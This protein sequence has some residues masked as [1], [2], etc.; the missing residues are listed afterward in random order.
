MFSGKRS[1]EGTC[2]PSRAKPPGCRAAWPS[3]GPRAGGRREAGICASEGTAQF[4]STKRMSGFRNKL[5]PA[6]M[7]AGGNVTPKALHVESTGTGTRAETG[8]QLQHPTRP[9]PHP[10]PAPHGAQ[11][12]CCLFLQGKCVSPGRLF[13]ARVAFPPGFLKIVTQAEP[14]KAL[15]SFI[16]LF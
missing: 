15:F 8:I 9:T 2:P 10:G 6:G 13:P 16:S 7:Q 3:Q 4:L 5:P 1:S 12:P 14:K 11:P